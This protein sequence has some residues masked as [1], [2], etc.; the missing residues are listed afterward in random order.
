MW[1][2][3]SLPGLVVV[4]AAGVVRG[5]L[6]RKDFVRG[7]VTETGT[8]ILNFHCGAEG[9]ERRDGPVLICSG[10]Q[11]GRSGFAGSGDLKAV[12]MEWARRVAE[13]Y[14]R[15]RGSSSSSMGS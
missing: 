12:P 3:S 9:Y 6:E 14:F 13:A 1:K 2:N 7:R 8:R 10:H 15:G 11:V 4:A 5:N